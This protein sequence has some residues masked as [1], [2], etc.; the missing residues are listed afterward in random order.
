MRRA[1]KNKN[2]AKINSR[3]MKGAAAAFKPWLMAKSKWGYDYTFDC[4]GVVRVMRDALEV[5]HIGWGESC[6]IGV[7]AAGHEISTR[8]FQLVTGRVWKG[9]AFGGA[10]GRTGFTALHD[11]R[12]KLYRVALCVDMMG[13]GELEAWECEQKEAQRAQLRKEAA[14]RK[15]ARKAQ[16]KEQ[17]EE[18]GRSGACT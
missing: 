17:E 3:A 4:T 11:G 2:P 8:P 16:E 15:E 5:A 6:V 7:A 14:E 9:T 12:K 18:D 1:R 10:R 13:Q